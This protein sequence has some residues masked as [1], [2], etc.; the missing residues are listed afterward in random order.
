[1]CKKI[2]DLFWDL[3]ESLSYQSS[4]SI[5]QFFTTEISNQFELHFI[6]WYNKYPMIIMITKPQEFSNLVEYIK[7]LLEQN[8]ISTPLNDVY[9]KNLTDAKIRKKVNLRQQAV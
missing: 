7:R 5:D 2:N 4:L 3:S 9:F 6:V 8:P 1:M